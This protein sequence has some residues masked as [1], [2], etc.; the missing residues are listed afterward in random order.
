M[1]GV[2]RSNE[3][4]G[5]HLSGFTSA[6]TPFAAAGILLDTPCDSIRRPRVVRNPRSC[7]HR[8]P[9]VGGSTDRA[10][11]FPLAAVDGIQRVKLVDIAL[12]M[13]GL[14]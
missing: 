14:R 3:S 5:P 6:A 12:S 7:A 9:L 13:A 4:T 8:V 10:E 1:G 11:W 2:A